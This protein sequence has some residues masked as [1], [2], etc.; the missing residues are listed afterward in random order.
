MGSAGI[1]IDSCDNINNQVD[2][3]VNS[4]ATMIIRIDLQSATFLKFL[5]RGNNA[6]KDFLV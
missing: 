4:L 2:S 5:A 3:A 6:S 1:T